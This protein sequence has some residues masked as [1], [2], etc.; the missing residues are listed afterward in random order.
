[1][2]IKDAISAK[3]SRI[4]KEAKAPTVSAKATHLDQRDFCYIEARVTT[5]KKPPELEE[6]Y[7]ESQAGR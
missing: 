3:F 6:A 2:V 7:N 1:M 4:S 5:R